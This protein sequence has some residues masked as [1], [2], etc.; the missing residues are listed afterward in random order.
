LLYAGGSGKSTLAKVLYN[1]LA[2]SFPHSVF[3]EILQEDG[4]NKTAQHLTTALTGLGGKIM[5]SAA[6][7]VLSQQIRELV[8]DKKVLFVLDNVW[9]ASQLDKLLPAKWGDGSVVIVTSRFRSLSESQCWRQ[10]CGHPHQLCM[11]A[12][13]VYAAACATI[14]TGSAAP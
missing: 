6:Q 12:G 13:Q 14:P 11:D 2:G 1:R 4:A 3:V 5:G 7:P 10:V 9:T 8:M